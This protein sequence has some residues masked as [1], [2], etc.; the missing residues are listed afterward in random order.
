MPVVEEIVGLGDDISF[1]DIK[2]IASNTVKLFEDGK[3]DEIYMFYNH[4]VSAIQQEVTEKKLL[5]LSDIAANK[6]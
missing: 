2:E 3:V 1:S 6:K 4:Y 5:P